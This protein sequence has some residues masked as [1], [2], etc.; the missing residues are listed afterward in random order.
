M[1][2]GVKMMASV[3]VACVMNGRCSFDD[4]SDRVAAGEG[5]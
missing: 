5:W 2:E 4:H 3:E 1:P